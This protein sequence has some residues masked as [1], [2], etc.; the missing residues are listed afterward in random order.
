MGK[1]WII[2]I[3][4]G[5]V[6]TSKEFAVSVRQ[7]RKYSFC[8]TFI[9]HFLRLHAWKTTLS[10]P[11]EVDERLVGSIRFPIVHTTYISSPH[12]HKTY[13]SCH[14]VIVISYLSTTSKHLEKNTNLWRIYSNK[15]SAPSNTTTEI[16]ENFEKHQELTNKGM[17]A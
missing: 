11:G 10:T 16:L 17:C 14:L 8:H 5:A 6:F 1:G 12:I 3:S 4:S 15:F 13:H 7:W 9:H 2:E